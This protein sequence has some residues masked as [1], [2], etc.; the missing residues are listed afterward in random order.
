[1]TT[2]NYLTCQFWKRKKNLKPHITLNLE[3]FSKLFKKYK[4]LKE[5]YINL[6]ILNKKIDIKLEKKLNLQKSQFL[7]RL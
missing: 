6:R 7:S 5:E 2:T 3:K 1:M 4:K